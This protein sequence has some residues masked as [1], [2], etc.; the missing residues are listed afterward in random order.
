MQTLGIW[1]AAINNFS[2]KQRHF[3]LALHIPWPGLLFALLG[4]ATL[5]GHVDFNFCADFTVP[6]CCKQV[7]S[8]LIEDAVMLV[9]HDHIDLAGFALFSKE[10]IEI[11]LPGSSC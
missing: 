8:S 4:P 7:Q 3:C 2:V 10:C 5:P 6:E 1:Q 9:S 11:S